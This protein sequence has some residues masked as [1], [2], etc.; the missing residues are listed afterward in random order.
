MQFSLL[1]MMY[2]SVFPI[3][4]SIRASNTYENQSLGKYENADALDENQTGTSYVLSHARNQLSFDLWWIML[5]VFLIT[6]V[7]S[8]RVA[9]NADPAFSVFA[10]L[11]EVTSAYGNVG[12][13]L[14]YPTVLTSLSGKFRLL[15]KLVICAMM[16]RGRHRGLPYALD[17]AIMLPGDNLVQNEGEDGENLDETSPVSGENRLKRHNTY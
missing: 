17:S 11:F 3:A 7:E 13:S 1:V 8:D 16:I 12:L 4:F 2:I 10:I 15:S 5:G 6:I 14:G 9:D